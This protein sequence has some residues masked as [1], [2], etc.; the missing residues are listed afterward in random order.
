MQWD[1]DDV[2]LPR[3]CCTPE[4]FWDRLAQRFGRQDFDFVEDPEF[5]AAYQLRGDDEAAIQRLFTPDVRR[6]LVATPGQHVAGGGRHLF[7]WRVGK[8]PKPDDLDTFFAEGDGVR[9][10]FV[11]R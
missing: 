2:A 6:R 11:E 9:Q 1:G 10:L 4:G 8:L 5:S 3:F 7:W